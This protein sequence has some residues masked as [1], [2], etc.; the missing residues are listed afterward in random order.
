MSTWI[1]LVCEQHDEPVQAE[2]DPDRP[3]YRLPE[4]LL[5]Q[6]SRGRA[7]RHQDPR[8]PARARRLPLSGRDLL[9]PRTPARG[10]QAWRGRP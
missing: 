9:A 3:L 7:C 8:T 4:D 5:R 6:P 10:G 1:Y 2:D